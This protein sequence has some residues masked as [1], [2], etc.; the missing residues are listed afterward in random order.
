M[1]IQSSLIGRDNRFQ[2]SVATPRTPATSYCDPCRHAN[3]VTPCLLTPCLQRVQ[4][5]GIAAMLHLPR[6]KGGYFVRHSLSVCEGDPLELPIRG[7]SIPYSSFPCFSKGPPPVG[8]WRR[9]KRFRA[10]PFKHQKS[11]VK[12]QEDKQEYSGMCPQQYIWHSESHFSENMAK[13]A[14]K[15]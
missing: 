12:R 15:F 8:N 11:R 2:Y 5:R 13:N 1:S 7:S 10:V 4:D 6:D 9:I 3:V 14:A